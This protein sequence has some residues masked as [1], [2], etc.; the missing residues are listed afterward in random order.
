MDVYSFLN[1]TDIIVTDYSSNYYDYLFTEKTIILYVYD[2]EEYLTNDKGFVLDYF[3]YTPGIKARTLLELILAI[4]ECLIK[5][6]NIVERNEIK[7]YF[8]LIQ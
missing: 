8:L 1:C 2:Y 7:K 3:K 4:K 6:E 5:D